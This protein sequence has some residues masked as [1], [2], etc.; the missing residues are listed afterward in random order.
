MKS[1]RL[2]LVMKKKHKRLQKEYRRKIKELQD[3]VC[4]QNKFTKAVKNLLHGDQINFMLHDY[5]KMPQWC[6]STLIKAY[7]IKFACGTS[8]YKELLNQGFPLPSLRT[9]SRK[10]ENLKFK[11]GILDEVLEFLHIKVS[12]LKSDRD[13]DCLI[14][15]DEISITPGTVFDTST[16]NYV[17]YVTLPEHD[18]KE[19]ATH[20][21]VFMLASIGHRW[22]QSIAYYFTA[23]NTKGSIYKHI[24]LEIILKVEKIGLKI[25]G[26]VSDMGSANQAMWR[27]FNINVSR[28]ST[29]KNH[30]V[31]PYDTTRYLYF[32]HDSSHALKNF[33]EG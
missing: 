30:C 17:G 8:G 15:L 1:E 25:H 13:R 2:R 12:H 20:G 32:F 21:L 19:I 29:V 16:N 28:N 14:V 24:I 10:L 7:Q 22:K 23:K 3:Q 27:E 26:I 33:K 6:N 5:K 11:S 4:F 18:D 31:H 9:L